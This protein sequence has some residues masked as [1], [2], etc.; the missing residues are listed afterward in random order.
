MNVV[1]LLLTLMS[2]TVIGNPL[3]DDEKLIASL[4]ERNV[5]CKDQSYDQKLKSLQIYL[6]KK[7]VKPTRLIIAANKLLMS[8]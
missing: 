6:S 5:I 4:V 3:P 8:I 2:F 7:I 1:F